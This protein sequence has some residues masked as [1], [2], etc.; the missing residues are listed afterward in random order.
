[1]LTFE[2]DQHVRKCTPK[3]KPIA[4]ALFSVSKYATANFRP[5]HG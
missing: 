2:A 1:L 3:C 5:I 4:L